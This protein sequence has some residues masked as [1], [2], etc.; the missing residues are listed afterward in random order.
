M[1]YLSEHFYVGRT[2]WSRGGSPF[3]VAEHVDEM[4]QAIR[5][6]ADG[7]RQLQDRLG[8]TGDKRVP[9]AMDE[10]NYWHR[11]YDFGELGCRYDLSDALGVAVGLHEYFRNTD[12]IHM[13]HYA[14]TVNVIGCIKTT[15]TDAFMATTALPLMIYRKHFGKT[16]IELAIDG[17]AHGVDISAAL[18]EGGKVLTLGIVNP[19]AEAVVIDLAYE[20]RHAIREAEQWV[21]AGGDPRA[22]NDADNKR[23]DVAHSQIQLG[24]QWTAPGYSFAVIRV[25]LQ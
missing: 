2:P 25:P 23:L 6:K 17:Q 15:K 4:R 19:N 16:P 21:V 11:D 8:L 10:W 12:I 18:D 24:N 1:D 5:K 13:A 9:I 20:G 7:H 22:Y 3:S 14:Q